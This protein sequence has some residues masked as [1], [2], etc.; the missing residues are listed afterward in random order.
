MK[1]LFFIL[2]FII[3]TGCIPDEPFC[4]TSTYAECETSND[5]IDAGCSGQICQS[6]EEPLSFTT[7]EFKPC[8]E[9]NIYGVK[10]QCIENK[11]QWD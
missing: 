6:I 2:F 9:P 7:C 3:F 1:K 10:C 4:G 8:Y 5:C 11:C